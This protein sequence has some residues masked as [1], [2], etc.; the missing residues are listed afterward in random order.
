MK[1]LISI[2]ILIFVFLSSVLMF[3][4]CDSTSVST[5]DNINGKIDDSTSIKSAYDSLNKAFELTSSAKDVI[6]KSWHFTVYE[7]GKYS[8]SGYYYGYID[9]A[10]ADYIG[11]DY[12]V[13]VDAFERVY[14]KSCTST[15]FKTAISN[16]ST[17]V[18]LIVQILKDK[19]V[20]SAIDSEMKKTKEVLKGINKNNDCYEDLMA[21]YTEMVS[22]SE[23]IKSP[24]GSFSGLENTVSSYEKNILGYKNKLSIYID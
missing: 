12:G 18:P 23:F 24:S 13:V 21:Y 10:Y 16:V 7:S 4:A 5:D 8:A 20:Y 11:V 9:F 1:K 22:F 17:G 19:G 2:I 6:Y 15:W 14:D 3:T